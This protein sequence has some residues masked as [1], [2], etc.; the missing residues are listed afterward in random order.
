MLQFS[1]S[2]LGCGEQG[3]LRPVHDLS[4][5]MAAVRQLQASY[6]PASPT[7][8]TQHQHNHVLT[9]LLSQ[10]LA[11]TAIVAPDFI[12]VRQSE[13]AYANVPVVA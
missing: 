11:C 12:K 5:S 13:A 1:N 8:T 9:H 2:K 6:K 4:G 10:S 3:I 7:Y